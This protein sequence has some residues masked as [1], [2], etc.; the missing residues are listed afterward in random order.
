MDTA[1]Q[2][3]EKSPPNMFSSRKTILEQTIE[4]ILELTHRERETLLKMLKGG[5]ICLKQKNN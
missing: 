2:T 4:S 5:T 3:I 1:I